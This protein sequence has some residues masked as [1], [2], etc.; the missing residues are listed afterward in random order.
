MFYQTYT[1]RRPPKGQKNVIFV[2]GDLDLWPWHSHSSERGTKHVFP[3]NLAQ[4]SSTVPQTFYIQTKNKCHSTIELKMFYQTQPPPAARS[5]AVHPSHLPAATEWSRLLLCDFIC[6][7]R[8]TMHFQWER[9][10]SLVTSTFDLDIQTCPSKE[11]NMSSLW[12]WRKSVQ[13]F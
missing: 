3:V 2:P 11:A 10:L 5:R 1:A 4:I 6:S 7:E 8:V 12:I 9:N 13:R